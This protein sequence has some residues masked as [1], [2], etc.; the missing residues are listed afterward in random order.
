[1]SADHAAVG[2]LQGPSGRKAKT[3]LNE[4]E[5]TYLRGFISMPATLFYSYEFIY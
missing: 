1:M 5:K 4:A 2:S 3:K